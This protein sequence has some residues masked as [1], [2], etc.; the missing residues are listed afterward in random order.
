MF[1][2]TIQYVTLFVSLGWAVMIPKNEKSSPRV[3]QKDPAGC[4][5]S[6]QEDGSVLSLLIADNYFSLT[7][8][9]PELRRFNYTWGGPCA[10]ESGTMRVFV[11]QQ[12]AVGNEVAATLE[13]T[14]EGLKFNSTQFHNHDNANGELAGCWRITAREQNGKMTEMQKGVRKT[15]KIMTGSH[16]QWVAM[17]TETGEFFGTGGGKY[18]FDKG[19][20]TENIEFF[21]RDSSRVGAKLSF[22]GRVEGNQWHHSGKSSKGDPIYEIW[23][24]EKQL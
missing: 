16:F 21:S 10:I 13:W 22:E 20:Y 12:G 24:R 18:T 11:A 5:L 17:N 3:I 19:Q 15:L 9:N 4:Y 1:M 2:S 7:S 14:K 6:K 23:T 8:Y